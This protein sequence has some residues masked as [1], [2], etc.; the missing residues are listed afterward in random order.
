MDVEIHPNA[1]KHL[2]ESRCLALG[3][4]LLSAFVASRRASR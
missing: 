4:R 3:L 2:T 1:K